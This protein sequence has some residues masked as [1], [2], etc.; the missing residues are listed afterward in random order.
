MAQVSLFPTLETERLLLREVIA[1]D[2]TALFSIH[3]DEEHMRLFGNDPISDV[4][5]AEALIKVFA[6]W[7][8]LPNPRTRWA[9]EI[10]GK[11]GLIGTCG[12]FAWNRNW[13]RC[14]CGFELTK[15]AQGKGYMHE[16]LSATISWGFA[17]M[18]LNRVEA[19]VHPGNYASLRLLKRLHFVEEGRLRQGGYWGGQ[20]HDLLQ[21]SLL[22]EDWI[23]LQSS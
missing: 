11:P 3:G 17:A 13:R 23:S 22:R 10:K 16:A 19:Q 8:Q 14:T 2:A 20:L 21:F 1:D 9:L 6:S 5:G 7:R 12:L 15:K 4:T 18:D